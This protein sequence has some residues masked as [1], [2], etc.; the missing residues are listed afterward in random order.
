[1]KT[2]HEIAGWLGERAIDL[3]D[4]ERAVPSG[5]APLGA[6]LDGVRVV[7]LGEATHG[8]REFFLLK[9]VLLRHLVEDLGFTVLAMEASV[10]AAAA[11]DDYVTG[12]ST[13]PVEA[14]RELGFWTWRTREVLA[15]LEWLREHN[16][17]VPASAQVRFV[18]IDPQFAQASL[19]WL[20]ANTSGHAALLDRL[21][22]VAAARLG[23]GRPLDPNLADDARHLMDALA[24]APG[25]AAAHARTVW[26]CASLIARP[27]RHTDPRQTVSA[28]RDE[29]LA[30][31]VGLLL[32]DPTAR[33]AVWAHNGH[34]KKSPMTG[35]DIPTM[36]RHLA[37]RLGDAYYALGLLFGGGTFRARRMRFGRPASG[38]GPGTRR[39]PPVEGNPTV[40]ESWLAAVE[41]DNFVVDLRHGE[42][43]EEVAGWLSGRNNMR[44]F[45][46]AVGWLTYKFSFMP[47]VLAD[48]FDGLAYVARGTCSRPL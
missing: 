22:P 28:L 48:D 8:T 14:L 35:T 11:V 34:V 45:G 47:T 24:Q 37:H 21:S 40:V 20:S 5:S 25:D 18:G 44:A 6:A 7:G 16:R 39:V 32:R 12:G 3:G 27:F 19:Q 43:P 41:P 33:V 26:Q 30:D 17:T 29:F 31:N 23:V 9:H 10:S 42:R 2:T 1:M 46:A 36:G 4:L 13:D 15:V 38:G